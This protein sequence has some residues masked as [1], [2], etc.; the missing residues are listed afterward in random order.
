MQKMLKVLLVQAMTEVT[1]PEVNAKIQDLLT[2]IEKLEAAGKDI[3]F[4]QSDLGVLLSGKKDLLQIVE[5]KILKVEEAAKA[6]SVVNPMEEL[7]K[8]LTGNNPVLSTF[9]EKV[10][11]AAPTQEQNPL[12]GLNTIFAT[13]L[14]KVPDA[15][16]ELKNLQKEQTTTETQTTESPLNKKE[17]VDVMEE[18]VI[19]DGS[20]GVVE[21]EEEDVVVEETVDAPKVYTGKIGV[22]KKD[23][24]S[25]WEATFVNENGVL[26]SG[27][28][29]AKWVE[30]V[31]VLLPNGHGGFKKKKVGYDRL[32]SVTETSFSNPK[33]AESGW[34]I[35]DTGVLSLFDSKIPVIF[36]GEQ[37]GLERVLVLNSTGEK[38]PMSKEEVRKYL[39]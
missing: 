7:L 27:L 4:N 6:E 29:I 23:T 11:E 39:A 10:K 37:K 24:Q 13:L 34:K 16:E 35:Y 19:L 14:S 21:E 1:A 9:F 36:L 22:K 28:I 18:D 15:L 26:E 32:V 33:P 8:Q 3:D 17:D 38:Y 31:D 30:R 2:R 25:G 20:N 12:Q 5:A